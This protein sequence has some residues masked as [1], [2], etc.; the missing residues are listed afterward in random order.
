MDEPDDPI[1]VEAERHVREGE[2]RVASQLGLVNALDA[3]GKHEDAR[4]ARELLATMTDS[5]NAARRYLQLE[6]NRRRAS[7]PWYL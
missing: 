6:Q 7:H 2:E 3:K 5:L 1:L 4:M